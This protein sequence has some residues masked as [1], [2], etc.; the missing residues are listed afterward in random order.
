MALHRSQHPDCDLPPTHDDYLLAEAIVRDRDTSIAS[1]TTTGE[2][3]N[4]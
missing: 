2:G 1:R 4:R 3:D